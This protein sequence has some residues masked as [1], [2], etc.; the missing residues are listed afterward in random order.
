M[1]CFSGYWLSDHNGM[2]FSTRDRD[3][4]VLSDGNCA[5]HYR[6]GW[7]Y[8]GCGFAHLN[9][10]VSYYG[11]SLTPQELKTVEMKIRPQ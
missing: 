6:A 8:R 7:W 5:D 3:N 1:V 2:A 11:K 4:D 9:D 10:V